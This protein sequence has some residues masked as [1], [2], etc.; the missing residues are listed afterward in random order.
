MKLRTFEEALA[1]VEAAIAAHDMQTLAVRFARDDL[2]RFD[3]AELVRRSAARTAR[4]EGWVPLRTAAA[5]AGFAEETR[6]SE[7]YTLLLTV[8]Q[9][10]PAVAGLPVDDDVKALLYDEFVFVSAPQAKYMDVL[11]PAKAA[12]SA[13]C[14]MILLK[15]FP[16]GQLHWEASG[17][18]RSW[19]LR[20]PPGDLPR[21]L[22]FLAHRTR[23]FSPFF[24]THLATRWTKP[25]VMLEAE[26]VKSCRRIARSMAMQPGV[27]GMI[28]S[29]WL[30]DPALATLAPHLAWRFDRLRHGAILTTAGPA[31]ADSG[32]ARLAVTPER[33]EAFASWQPAMGVMLWPRDDLLAWANTV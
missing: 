3:F 9:T 13:L 19:L 5:E 17:F 28:S 15:R 29:S 4:A 8:R 21:L 11:N 24:G 10:L 12:F 33:A 23:G 6:A 2:S 18:P 30:N 32:A 22:W 31:P 7:R 26:D 27:R 1:A 14:R 16:A 20:V 25:F